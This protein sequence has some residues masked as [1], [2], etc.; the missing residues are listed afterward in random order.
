MATKTV[1]INGEKFSLSNKPSHGVVRKIKQEQTRIISKF[2]TAHKADVEM[3]IKENKDASIET[4]IEQIVVNNPDEALNYS[5]INEDFE[6]IAAISLAT[7]KMWAID[8]FEDVEYNELIKIHEKCNDVI[9]GGYGSFLK[10][11]QNILTPAK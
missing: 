1:T 4:A 11:S 7:N 10:N 8:D 3:F 2:L 9:G 6:L 5:I